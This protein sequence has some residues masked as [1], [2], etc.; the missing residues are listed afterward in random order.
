[1]SNQMSHSGRLYTKEDLLRLRPRHRT[2]VG[3][4]SDG[5]VFDTMEVKQKHHFHPIIIRFW[6]LEEIEKQ[7]REAAEFF[8]LYSRWRGQNRFIGLLLT[9]KALPDMPG[10]KESGVALPGYDRLEAYVNSG[11]PLGN[12]SLTEE[13]NRTNDPELRRL[14]EW[15][16]AINR[17]I[18]ENMGTILPFKWARESIEQISRDSDLIVVSQTP[19]EAL[20]KEWEM[21]D[22]ASFPE[23]IAGQELGTKTEHLK[24]ATDGRYPPDRI[25]MIGD[26]PGDRKAA[27]DN[28]AFF[29]PIDPGSEEESWRRFHEEAYKKFLAGEYGGDYQQ[30]L[31]AEFEAILPEKLPWR[32]G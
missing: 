23:A 30:E 3:I 4:D 24:M 10:V 6:G 22:L 1:M 20:V 31:V 9:F 7:L 14:L 13:V 32:Q 28:H 26:A 19:E 27:E 21:H 8:N 29:Y 17:D 16:L 25:L 18:D 2:F 12:P 15:S 5:C 11:L